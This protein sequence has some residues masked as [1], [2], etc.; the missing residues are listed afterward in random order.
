[1]AGEEKKKDEVFTIPNI[2]S[3]L[4]ITLIPL[5]MYFFF[6]DQTWWAVGTL[7]L[8]GI[9]DILDGWIARTFNQVSDLGKALDPISDKL[10][11]IAVL[12]CL[13]M[14]FPERLILPLVLVIVKEF[15]TGIFGLMTLK[16]TNIVKGARWY[17]KLTTV[18]LYFT[19]AFHLIWSL[20]P[21]IFP[22]EVLPEYLSWGGIIL[23]CVLMVVS[24]IL[25]V[26]RYIRIMKNAASGGEDNI[27]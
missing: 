9:S 23:S 24:F 17:G 27:R 7:L 6:A 2:I 26:N 8:S 22:N 3:F 12:F 16:R 14:R 18:V 21:E 4:R 1:M 25:Y 11:Q 13:V 15:V 10:T 20:F 5:F 19:M